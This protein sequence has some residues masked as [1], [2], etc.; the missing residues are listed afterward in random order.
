MSELKNIYHRRFGTEI[1]IRR[2]MFE[3]LCSRVFQRY[4]PPDAVVL[5][6]GAGYCE[7]INSI[8]GRRK[9]ALDL[10]PDAKQYADQG[11]EVHLAPSSSMPFIENDSVDTVFASNI[12]EHLSR[13]DIG[14]TLKEVWRILKK[15]GRILILQPNIRYCYR[16]YWMF[17]DHITPLDDRSLSE[18]LEINRLQVVECKPRFLPYT[19]KGKLPKSILLLKVYLMIPILH[20]I[21]GEQAFIVARKAV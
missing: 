16:D 7:F 17:F 21:F 19:T 2:A 18:A 4:V 20:R 9:I 5:D 13:E 1:E 14:A 11:I 3:V 8:K 6:V 12:F 15:D 10:N